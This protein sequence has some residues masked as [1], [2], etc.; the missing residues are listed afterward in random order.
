MT[1][2]LRLLFYYLWVAPHVLQVIILVLLFRRGIFSKFPVFTAYTAFSLCKF[3]ALFIVSHFHNAQATYFKSYALAVGVYAALRFGI[4]CEIFANVFAN[5]AALHNVQKP[6]FR[7]TAV[8]F[9]IVAFSLAVYTNPSNTDLTWFNLHL[10]ERSAN[11]VLCGLLL[12][13][14]LFSSYLRLTWT[15]FVFGM[16]LGLGILCSLELATTAMRA[17]VGYSAHVTLDLFDMAVYHCCV[18][19]WLF[20]LLTPERRQP[21][22]PDN[23][24]ESDLEAWNHELESLLTQ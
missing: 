20:Y 23:V 14:F 2:S 1:P 17:Q 10:L 9:L 3:V 6:L 11:I 21:S 4:I 19:I 7:W 24:T 12:S 18:L 15:R 13:L 16:A 5:H 22:I 8:S